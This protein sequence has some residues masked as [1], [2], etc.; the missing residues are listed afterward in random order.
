MGDALKPPS[1]WRPTT[2]RLE[3]AVLGKLAE[4][5]A[6]LGAATARCII[7]GIEEADPETGEPNRVWL[8]KEIADVEAMIEHA[9]VHYGLDRE[10]IA[11]RRS[12]KIRHKALWHD[13]IRRGEC[14]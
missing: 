2:D 9:K 14:D 11:S 13:M 6:E 4:E 3:L 8:E 5:C 10:A 1:P 12:R 7:Q